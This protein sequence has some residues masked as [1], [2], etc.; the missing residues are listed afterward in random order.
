MSLLALQQQIDAAT[1]AANKLES[2]HAVKSQFCEEFPSKVRSGI[3]RELTA[4]RDVL[5]TSKSRL[6]EL[7]TMQATLDAMEDE[8]ALSPNK[9]WPS[10][11]K[12]HPPTKSPHWLP[13]L[14]RKKKFFANDDEARV[15]SH[16][17]NVVSLAL[18]YA[19]LTKCPD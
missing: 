9:R 17:T 13:S 8:P 3:R 15:R 16:G 12:K 4:F 2:E 10:F 6:Q 18:M 7:Q 1:L 14:G 5:E 11:P 19:A